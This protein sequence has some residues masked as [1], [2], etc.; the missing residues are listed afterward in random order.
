MNKTLPEIIIMLSFRNQK[1]GKFKSTIIMNS[2]IHML[3][4]MFNPLFHNVEKW[5][6]IL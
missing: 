2:D 1:E 3:I 5:P 6:N 4:H